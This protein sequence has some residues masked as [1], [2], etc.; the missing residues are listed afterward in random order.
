VHEPDS[1]IQRIN[2]TNRQDIVNV[3]RQFGVNPTS[4]TDMGSLPTDDVISVETIVNAGKEDGSMLFYEP[5]QSP[6]FPL[7]DDDFVVVIQS[8]HQR[9]MFEQYGSDLVCMDSTHGTTGYDFNLTSEYVEVIGE[10]NCP[11]TQE[12]QILQKDILKKLSI[13]QEKYSGTSLPSVEIM[14]EVTSN[15]NSAIKLGEIKRKTQSLAFSNPKEPANKKITPQKRFKSVKKGR[16]K[17]VTNLKKAAPEETQATEELI[18]NAE[19][20]D[21]IKNLSC[22]HNYYL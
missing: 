20:M 13:L 4:T 16:R 17:K 12:A 1:K 14:K 19:T 8:D 15:L 6:Y 18:I 10:H 2:L 22:E 3:C 9:A 5:Q 11:T 21:A 7:Q